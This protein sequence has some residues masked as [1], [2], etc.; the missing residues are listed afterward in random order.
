[1]NASSAPGQLTQEPSSSA[2]AMP[3]ISRERF[4]ELSGIPDGVL[5][6]WIGKGYIPVYHV[7]K[8]CLVNLA[9]LNQMA[10]NKAP[11]L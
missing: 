5:K 7:G 1:M 2:L 4:A 3:L 8:Y 11:W 9:L 10:L 6:G